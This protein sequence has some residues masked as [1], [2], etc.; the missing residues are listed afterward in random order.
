MTTGACQ[1]V[2]AGLLSIKSYLWKAP[3]KLHRFAQA[4]IS[5]LPISLQVVLET[6]HF[7][8]RFMLLQ[9]FILPQQK[10]IGRVIRVLD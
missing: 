2:F 1:D 7:D 4:T 10:I 6:W 3:K 8:P 5:E 9:T